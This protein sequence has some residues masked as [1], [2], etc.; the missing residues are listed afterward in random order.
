MTAG[1]P[2]AG[3][4][5]RD[6]SEATF[7]VSRGRNG[8]PPIAVAG[9]GVVTFMTVTFLYA[10]E[11]RALLGVYRGDVLARL[12]AARADELVDV[13]RRPVV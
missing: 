11:V 3:A 1:L 4:L 5:L 6:A 7:G 2:F 9:F 13:R 8:P 12:G 10:S